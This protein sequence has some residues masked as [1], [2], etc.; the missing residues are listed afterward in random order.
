MVKP[1][2]QIPAAKISEFCNKWKITELSLFGSATRN[3]FRPESDIDVLVSFAAD[4]EWGLLEHA[5]MEE[6][7]SVLLGHKVDLVSRRAVERS[8]NQMRRKAI[9]ESAERFYAA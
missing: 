7:L 4:A 9:L 5:A 8:H 1:H 3:D 2:I 6:E